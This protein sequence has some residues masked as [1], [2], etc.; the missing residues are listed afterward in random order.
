MK[1]ILR[2][3]PRRTSATPDDDLVVIGDPLLWHIEADEVHISVTFT[4]DIKEG[5]RLRRAWSKH[6]K[7]VKLGGPAFGDRG[8]GFVPGLYLKEGATITSRGCV[9]NCQH[10]FVREREGNIRPLKI[11]DGFD[12]FDNNLLACPREHVEAVMDMLSRQKRAAR[13]SG[14]IDAHLVRPWWTKL[15]TGIR[16]EILYIAYDSPKQ[17]EAVKDAIPMLL[18]SGLTRRE[19]GCYVLAGYKA[20]TIA[21]AE[22][23]LR[24]VWGLGAMPFI[25]YYQPKN[26]K[27]RKVPVS[28][29]S[30]VK[31][32]TRPAIIKSRMRNEA[33]PA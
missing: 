32:W 21:E 9:R 22:K 6:N 28:W 17:K 20:D 14:G 1:R 15:L 30:F 10:C 23:R 4:W 26:A 19:I 24:F 16:T 29:R 8:N 3:F 25:M 7:N 5:Q 2:V 18:E 33:V 12:I 13:F 11:H 31:Q 27:R